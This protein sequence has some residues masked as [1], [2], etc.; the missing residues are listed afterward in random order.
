MDC[1]KVGELIRQLRTEKGLA[2]KQVAQRLNISNKTVS[3]W[4]R[5]LGCPDVSLWEQLAETLGADVLNLLQGQLRPNRP[6]P[7]RMDRV[8]FYVCPTCGDLLTSTGPASIACCGRQL[9]PLTPAAL[10]QEHRPH[11]AEV[12]DEYYVTV[13]HEMRKDHYLL[14]AACVSD[15]RLWL[16]R[17]YPEQTPAFR[18][19]RLPRAA[20]FY[21]YCTRHGL[22]KWDFDELRK[23]D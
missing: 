7:G 9:Q 3:K 23:T 14:F 22:L 2:Q 16:H 12:E 21:L 6:D 10:A 4:E 17:L 8:R 5:G 18:V 15:E 13:D 19:P 20:S 1:A 11:A